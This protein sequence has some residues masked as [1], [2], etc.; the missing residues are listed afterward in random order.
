MAS[1]A[2]SGRQAKR[3]PYHHGR[4]SDEHQRYCGGLDAHVA[5]LRHAFAQ[6]CNVVVA[7][8]PTYFA[9]L[10]CGGFEAEFAHVPPL[11][12]KAIVTTAQ[13][14]RQWIEEHGMVVIRCHD[15][16]DA[17]PGGIVDSLALA[18]GFGPESYFKS[19]GHHRGRTR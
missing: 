15:V 11:A 2:S 14:K 16:W 7:H 4:S 18:L 19:V 13:T 1:C 8:E 10:E 6:G 5:G 9:R 3:R 12:K 17:M